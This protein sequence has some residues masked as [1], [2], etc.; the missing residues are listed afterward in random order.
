M[1]AAEAIEEALKTE[2]IFS[3]IRDKAK[4]SNGTLLY[5]LQRRKLTA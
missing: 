2:T 4:V 5:Y 3:K 1:T